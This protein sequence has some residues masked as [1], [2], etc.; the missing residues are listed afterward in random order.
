M[1]LRIIRFVEEFMAE[2][3][4]AI[5]ALLLLISVT[6]GLLGHR[7]FKY[8]KENPQFC[9]TCHMMQE[10]YRGWEMSAHRDIICQRCHRM[11][12]LEQNRLL[13]T[14]VMTGYTSPRE[15]KHGRV[16][17]WRSCRD[18]H[19]QEA[20]QGSVSM[21]K[22]HGHARHVFMEGIDCME[23]HA[24]DLHNFRPNEEACRRCHGDRLVH[25]LGME[26]LSCLN[27]HS[28]AEETS[29]PVSDRKC[30]KC[31]R[32]IPREGYPMSGIH[33]FECHKPHAQLKLES[34]GC[35]GQCHGNEARVGQHGIHMERARLQCLDCHRAH[36][37]AVG[38]EQARGLCDR[39]HR[40]KDPRTFIY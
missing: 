21:R 14:Y 26:G 7:Y 36:T 17:P 1:L 19:M 32:G 10:S 35:L 4:G 38:R 29:E 25:G 16:E 13:V 11:S 12:M 5:I 39:C 30:L 9:A 2:H 3:R 34:A 18:C 8:T 31:H 40:M 6:G 37:W 15:E 20:Q 27:C 22:S 28:Y 33:C 23:C 24:S